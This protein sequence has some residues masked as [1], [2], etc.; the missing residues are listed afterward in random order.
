MST[1]IV[2]ISMHPNVPTTLDIVY[3]DSLMTLRTAIRFIRQI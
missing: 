1:L 3:T 2:M